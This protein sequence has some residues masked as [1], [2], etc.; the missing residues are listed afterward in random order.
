MRDLRKR[1]AQLVGAAMI[2]LSIPAMADTRQGTVTA[3]GLTI[4][5]MERGSATDEPIL[6]IQGVG[7]PMKAGPDP[8]ADQLVA[9]GFRWIT[10]DNRDSGGSTHFTDAGMPDYEAIKRAAAEGRPLPLAYTLSDMADDAVGVLDALDID[11]AHIV[12]GS[13]GGVI[14]QVLAANHPDRVLSLTLIST[15]TGNPDLAWGPAVQALTLPVPEAREARIAQHMALERMLIGPL[16]QIDEGVLRQTIEARLDRNDDPAA[17]ARQG[18]T[19][20]GDQRRLIARI[21]AA[22]E[23]VHGEVDLLFPPAHG[24]DVAA[25][26]PGAVLTIV[27]DMGHIVTDALAP[28]IVGAILRAAARVDD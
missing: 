13:L 11:R 19:I 15:T 6:F 9:A 20:S 22:T 18:I 21:E 1:L 23:V 2:C 10:F 4:A 27:P 14:A 8:I 24:Q 25:S 7:S 3:N 5:Y 17:T 26:I 12:G 28:V 16:Q